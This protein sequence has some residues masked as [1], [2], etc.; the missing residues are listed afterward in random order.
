[1]SLGEEIRR[2]RCERGMSQK[3]LSAELGVAES[4]VSHW[5]RDKNDPKAHHL[6]AI[7]CSLGQTADSL[8]EIGGAA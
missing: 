8:L 1:M 2:A 3:G 4:T 5:E 7:A 6:A